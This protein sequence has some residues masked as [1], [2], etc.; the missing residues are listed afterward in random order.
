M[1]DMFDTLVSGGL[2]VDGTGAP[3]RVGDIAIRDGRVVAVGAE[4]RGERARET[5]DADGLVVSPGFIDIHT[6]YDA[7]LMWDPAATPSCLHGVTTVLGG[8]CGFTLAPLGGDGGEYIRRLLA[9][10]EGMPLAALEAGL[11]WDWST[12]ADW[13]IRFEGNLGVNAGFLAG[14]S[15]IRWG[16]MGPDAVGKTATPGQVAEMARIL[17][18]YLEAGALGFSTSQYR[19]HLDGDGN[20][21]PSRWADRA[22]LLAL[23]AVVKDVPGTTLEVVNSGT[24]DGFSDEEIDLMA[25][26]SAAGNRPVNWNV[27]LVDP[28]R[29]DYNERQ[30][31]ASDYAAARGGSVVALTLPHLPRVLLRLTSGVS[32]QAVDV[33]KD[34]VR[35]PMPERIAHLRD[36]GYRGRLFAAAAAPESG[37]HG[38]RMSAWGEFLIAQ[39]FSEANAGLAGRTIGELAAERGTAPFDTFCDVALADDLQTGMIA[40][41][42][43][44]PS[45]SNWEMR[46]KTWLDP[47]TVI[48]GSDAG[49]HLDIICGAIYTTY[50]LGDSVRERQLLTLEQAVHQMSDV[51]ARLYG[52]KDRGRIEVGACADLT[53]FDPQTVKPGIEREVRDLPGN[54]PRL[55]ADA[56]GVHR[57][58]VNGA[59]VVVDGELTGATPGTMLRNQ[60]DTYTVTAA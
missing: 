13:A 4:A 14:H 52:L 24:L 60:E 7:Q 1:A 36:A 5:I 50:M 47:R 46:A 31:A 58:M 57:V 3:G 42:W 18:S 20:P 37:F 40:P 25:A 2:V 44:D 16:V 21:V 26:M 41:G 9:R 30:L 56:V 54:S 11:D 28:D 39:T 45:Q 32:F 34:L 10:V 48:G 17:R 59:S 33:W 53:L 19:N 49:A 55:Y 8:N 35:M 23:S 22:E 15:A 38:K 51:P 6:H 43:R 12:F 27:Y 29:P